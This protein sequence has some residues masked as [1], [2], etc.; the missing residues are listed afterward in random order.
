VNRIKWD[1]L[2]GYLETKCNFKKVKGKTTW[3]CDGELK[4]TKM[5][6]EENN[7]DFDKVKATLNTFGGYCDCEVLFNAVSHLEERFIFAEKVALENTS[8]EAEAKE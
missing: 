1:K 8:H 4:F 2:F 3:V 7:L 5:F 6:C